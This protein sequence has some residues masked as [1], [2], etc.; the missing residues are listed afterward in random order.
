MALTRVS[1]SVV[2]GNVS[3]GTYN[4]D[5]QFLSAAADMPTFIKAKLGGSV[6]Q[7]ELV[8]GD[9]FKSFEEAALEYSSIVNVFHAKSVLSDVMG[10]TTASYTNQGNTS[11][12]IDRTQLYP[13]PTTNFMDRNAD[14]VAA[15]AN[16]GG[17]QTVYTGSVNLVANQQDYNISALL[18]ASN[19]NG[20]E[21]TG[22]IKIRHV[23][24]TEPAA[25]YRFFNQTSYLNYLNNEF[26][27]ESFTP[28]TA[29]YLLPIFE[30]VLRA[31][32]LELNQRVRRSNFSFDYLDDTTIRL[33]PAP[34]MNDRGRRLWIIY[35]V[36]T[37]NE[38]YETDIP[39]DHAQ[40]GVSN[41]ANIPFGNI[42]FSKINSIGRNW[43]RRYTVELAREILG[44]VRGK[45]STIPIPNNDLTLNGPDLIT[46]ARSYQDSL[47]EELRTLLEDTTYDKLLEK[48]ATRQ[49]NLE[50]T[51][52]KIPLLMYMG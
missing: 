45:F 39:N 32:Q 22:K 4:S 35:G 8:N 46:N 26:K 36:S 48:D 10:S 41:I 30:D 37:N 19:P 9:V 29:F 47:K 31:G 52:K 34:T 20:V 49:Q 33:F 24:H 42:P 12:S 14:A 18:S 6:L 5:M 44:Q 11:G 23:F 25:S 1:A 3:F 13:N 15:A 51:Y 38:A 16:A 28:E 2:S 40:F 21:A 17:L 27:F 7:V 50:D 43:I